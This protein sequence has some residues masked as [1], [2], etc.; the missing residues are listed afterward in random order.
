MVTDTS[1][2]I[3]VKP[4]K[5]KTTIFDHILNALAFLSC[6]F[7]AVA[8]L[9]ITLNVLLRYFMDSPLPWAI[10]LSEYMMVGLLFLGTAWVLKEEGHV[11][12]DI[13]INRLNPRTRALLNVITSCVSAIACVVIVWYGALVTMEYFQ[14]GYHYYTELS[15]PK[16]PIYLVVTMGSFFLFIQ[17]LRMTNGYVKSWRTLGR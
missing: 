12:M 8:W 1:S 11:K 9:A 10:E 16:Y 3:G 13:V 14:A 6:I 5:S 17:F 7:I 2:D 4:L 15:P